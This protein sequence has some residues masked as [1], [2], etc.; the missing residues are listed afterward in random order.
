MGDPSWRKPAAATAPG[1]CGRR[2]RGEWAA[3]RSHSQPAPCAHRRGQ[4][5][6]SACQRRHTGGGLTVMHVCAGARNGTSEREGFGA[7]RTG[8]RA[9]REDRESSR[10]RRARR[11]QRAGRAAGRA[12]NSSSLCDSGAAGLELHHLYQRHPAAAEQRRAARQTRAPTAPFAAS[13]APALR[14]PCWASFVQP[15]Y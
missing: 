7:R 1:C 14:G 10:R 2:W 3:C 9:P 15:R 8:L 12:R 4:T 11:S 6:S 5:T 13:Q